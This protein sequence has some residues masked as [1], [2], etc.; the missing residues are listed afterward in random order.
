MP[1]PKKNIETYF[2]KL[3]RSPLNKGFRGSTRPHF[4]Y[5]TTNSMSTLHLQ[6]GG[7]KL[8]F[9]NLPVSKNEDNNMLFIIN[10]SSKDS[11]I[12]PRLQVTYNGKLE[13]EKKMKNFKIP[14]KGS[15]VL[16]INEVNDTNKKYFIQYINFN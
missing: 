9:I 1:L 12:T 3:Y 16:Y 4:F 10:P 7:H 5:E 11:F 15:K 13:K 14:S 8:N 6:D 2:V